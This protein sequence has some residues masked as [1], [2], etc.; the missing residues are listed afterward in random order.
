MYR[1][2]LPEAPFLE[3]LPIS[4]MAAMLSP[5]EMRAFEEQGFVTVDALEHPQGLTEEELQAAEDTFDRLVGLDSTRG[6]GGATQDGLRKEDDEGFMSLITHPF[7][8]KIAQQVISSEN[9][10]LIELGPHHRPPD[11]GGAAS[12]PT[13][14]EAK[15]R[16]ARG[17]HID[18]QVT[19]ADF[20]AT[21]RRDLL[22]LWFWVN[23]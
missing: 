20:N 7:F 16:W 4:A 12:K 2:G 3:R 11:E 10:R 15:E 9:V 1:G 6:G 17:C 19:T 18:L 5:A 22:A 14:E 23:E 8:E 13:P 21:P